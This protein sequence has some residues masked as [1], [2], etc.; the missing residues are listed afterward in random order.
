MAYPINCIRGIADPGN[1]SSDGQVMTGAFIFPDTDRG[2]GWFELSINWED[3][4]AA[5]GFSLT[6]TNK[7]GSLQFKAGVITFP[8]AEID[9]LNTDTLVRGLLSYERKKIAGNKYHG[10]LLL[11]SDTEKKVSRMVSANLGLLSG[12]QLHQHPLAH[13]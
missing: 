4:N 6:Q 11:K 9:R 7:D 13:S 3:D 12:A 10:N 8:K 2:D 1:V 5:V